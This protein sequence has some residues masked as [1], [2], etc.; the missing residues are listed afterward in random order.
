MNEVCGRVFDIKRFAVHDGD[1]IRTTVFLKGCP[2]KCIWCHNPEGISARPQI[3]YIEGKCVNCGECVGVCD[4]GVHSIVGGI[5]HA[6]LSKCI[7]CGKCEGVCL[8]NAIKQY[9]REMTAEQVVREVLKDKRFY[10]E[11]GGGVTLSGGECLCRA[12]F[13]REIL[14]KLKLYDINCAVDT[15]GYISRE[16]I[17]KVIDY[18]DIFLYDFK[19]YDN[20][21]HKK[22]TGH[23]NNIIKDNLLYINEMGVPV[24]IRI[25]LIPSI[26]DGQLVKIGEFIKNLRVVRGVRLLKY[27]NLAESKYTQLGMKN[28]MPKIIPP[29][30]ETMRAAAAVLENMGIDV[31]L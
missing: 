7:G 22:Y 23:G 21:I 18:T 16:N 5:H 27:N 26:N 29:D 15:S 10:D 4:A 14:Q 20:D 3:S 19:F 28:T 30:D 17:R 8:G 25:P 12:D 24:E 9:G 11:S 1:G 31:I 6:D 13:C 2:L